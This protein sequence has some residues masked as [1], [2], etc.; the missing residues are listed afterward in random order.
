MTLQHQL[1][2]FAECWWD[3][4]ILD[5]L[6]CNNIGIIVGLITC[7]YLFKMKEF[8]WTG[9]WATKKGKLVRAFVPTSFDQYR[10]E[11]FANWRRF[12]SVM[13]LCAAVSIIELNAFYLKYILWVPPPHPLN[14]ARL[15]LWLF[16][17]LPAL[18]EYYQFVSDPNCGKMGSMTWLCTLVFATEGLIC[19]K[20]GRGMFPNPAPP[21]VFWPWVIFLVV[22]TLAA[23]I[24]FYAKSSR[25]KRAPLKTKSRKDRQKNKSQAQK[26]AAK[27]GHNGKELVVQPEEQ[28]KENAREEVKKV[29]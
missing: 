28:R 21:E 22:G 3:H 20:F 16:M 6:I 24:F 13:L 18:R 15:F 1:P 27:N 11:I 25:E 29:K 4:V 17:G 10:W 2:N 19:I 26:Q 7:R 8:N 12:V 23:F 14:I 5:I 9:L